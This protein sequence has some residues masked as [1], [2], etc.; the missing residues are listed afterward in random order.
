MSCSQYAP[1]KL[2]NGAGR[3]EARSVWGQVIDTIREHIRTS[4]KNYCGGRCCATRSGTRIQLTQGAFSGRTFAGTAFL[5]AAGTGLGVLQNAGGNLYVWIGDASGQ[6]I[7]AAPEESPA[8]I[9]K[10][11]RARRP[12][13]QA[14]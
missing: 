8:G 2:A 12:A 3:C 11:G 9:L 4:K 1:Y 5:F 14:K 10:S 7:M 13:A 6:G